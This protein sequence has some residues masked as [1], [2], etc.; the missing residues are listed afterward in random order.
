M[1]LQSARIPEVV[2]PP[3]A[4]PELVSAL[5]YGHVLHGILE[6]EFE[7]LRDSLLAVSG[8]LDDWLSC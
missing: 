1:Q 4:S 3:A 2:P 5:E 7:A 6:K 8:K